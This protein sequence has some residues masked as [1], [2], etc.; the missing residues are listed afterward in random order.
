VAVDGARKDRP[1]VTRIV[2][3]GV[4]GAAT[5]VVVGTAVGW[6]YASAA[7]WTAAAAVFAAWTWSVIGGMGPEQTAAHATRE[8]P[9]RSLT[10]VIVLLASVASLAGVVYLLAA[11]SD[12]GSDG[13]VAGE[14]L[15][16]G[17]GVASVVAAWVVV[18]TVF[19]V[20]YALLYYCDEPGGIDFNGSDEPDYADFA[21]LAFTLGMTYQ[22]SDTSL[23][24]RR[25][26]ATALRHALLSYVLGAVVL[27]AVVN[28]V[29]GLGISSG[30]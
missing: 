26:R 17:L 25:I 9:A 24:T 29:A 2:V 15:S 21:Y 11:G 23:R 3:A 1:V 14:A 19:T 22:V 13:G 4:V 27:A 16:A 8:D 28:L 12:G 30:G 5:A 20:R 7:G 6:R 10:D 18:H